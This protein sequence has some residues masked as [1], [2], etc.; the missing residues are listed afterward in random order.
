MSICALITVKAALGLDLLLLISELNRDTAA[1]A[2][3]RNDNVGESRISVEL[4]NEKVEVRIASQLSNDWPSIVLL[5]I[6]I[7]KMCA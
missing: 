1:S 5:I 3:R 4:F 6:I 2:S 7:I